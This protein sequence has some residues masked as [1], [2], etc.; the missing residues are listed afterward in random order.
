MQA[1][2]HV[3]P[4][5]TTVTLRPIRDD[6]GPRLLAMWD[7]TSTESRRRRFMGP[8]NLNEG[9]VDRFVTLDA[10]REFAVVA[11][12]GRDDAE[13]IVGVSQ[14]IRDPKVAD[15][16]EFAVLVED[17]EQGRGIGTA[18]V[19]AVARQAVDDG[20]TTLEGEV[21]AD[22][23]R[24]L[25]LIRELGLEFNADRSS[26]GV[27]RS[28]LKLRFD[29]QFLAA[30]D[31]DDRAAATAALTRFLQP[32]RIAVIGAS[33]NPQSIG[34][35]VFRNLL[36]GGFD[37]AV[38]PVNPHADTVQSIAAYPSLSAC[39]LTPDLV[40]VCVPAQHV[41]AVI[42]EAGDQGVAAVCIISAGFAETGAEGVERQADVVARAHSHG[43]RIIGPN[44]MGLMNGAADIRMNGTFSK[45]FP[46]PGRVSMSSQSGALGLAVIEHVERLGLGISTFISVG[47]KADVSGNDLLQYWEQDPNTDVILMYLES[48]GNPRKFA[49][50]AR[51]VGRHK[52]II[53]VK[54]G[55][56]TAGERAASSHTAALSAGDTAVGALFSQA[57]VIRTDTLEEMF[58]VATVL[59][60][61]SPP[62]GR[63]VAILTNAGGPAILAA[64]A[65][66]AQGLQVPHL[67]DRTI[68]AL[69]EFLPPE[70]GISNPVDMIASASPEQ[71]ARAVEVLGNAAEIDALVIIFI[72][73]GRM[74]TAEVV[75]ELCA[76]RQRVPE[77]VPTIAVMMSAPDDDNALQRAGIPTFAFP[78]SA[79]RALGRVWEY[80]RWRRRPLGT[81][82]EPDD[83]DRAA[84]RES[85]AAAYGSADDDGWVRHD[86]ATAILDAYGVTRAASVI[87]ASAEAGRQAASQLKAPFAVKVAA[88]IHKSDVGG[89]VLD[90]ADADAV[91][92][93]I[94]VI[95]QRMIAQGL[96]VYAD[97]F[98]VQEMVSD[99]VEM[100][101]GV[102]HDPSFGPL[103]LTGIGGTLVELLQDVALRITPI[104][105]NDVA[106]MIDGLRMRPLLQG[107]RGGPPADIDALKMLLFRINMLV[108]DMPEL[109]ELDLNPVFVQPQGHGVRAVDVRMRIS[110]SPA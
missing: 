48:F 49:R 55:R 47:N 14:Y 109:R 42:D 83:I 9:N 105:D 46:A 25:N 77:D 107:Y 1:H 88:G 52:P 23:V 15:H 26:A 27:V 101:V 80:E 60:M 13:R 100:V 18:L 38:Y 5:G 106:D 10:A 59:A 98:I 40:F 33:R 50:I 82:V 24:M 84:A 45:T 3:L 81:V 32:K 103:I 72:P 68:A 74:S 51:R 110:R 16:A 94:K 95:Q 108:E 28:D 78:E 43:L 96:E 30:V 44:C 6:D 61:Q 22:N 4:D 37:G 41:A 104:T 73:T 93:A 76:A 12:R 36:D 20:I 7:R 63:N 90:I 70:A 56:S 75:P 66:E 19:R 69:R 39:P 21:L 34:G 87:V 89:V 31:E 58:D 85:I 62:H 79:A 54:S 17:S 2:V 97:A 102:T 35:L 99:G 92:D 8:F 64:D 53:A 29:D 86:T 71:Y 91:A 11:S 57:G 65:L 67:T